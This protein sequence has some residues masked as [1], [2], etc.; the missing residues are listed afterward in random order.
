M[1]IASILAGSPHL[2]AIAESARSVL[3]N[4]DLGPLLVYLI[5]TTSSDALPYL[6]DQF[7]VLGYGGFIIAETEE[8]QRALLKKAL[9]LQRYKGTVWAIKESLQA[10]G[11]GSPDILEGIGG[12]VP[13]YDGTQQFDGSITFAD[14]S[15]YDWATFSVVLDL[16]E[17]RGVTALST[18]TAIKIIEEY[19]NARSRLIGVT[20]K[21]TLLDSIA[22]NDE[23]LGYS[24]NDPF[25][26]NSRGAIFSG[27]A[28]FSGAERYLGTISDASD[29]RVVNQAGNTVLTDNF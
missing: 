29:I 23:G 24:Q 15:A 7:G 1:N 18:E 26:E 16:G 14:A 8:Q 28:N 9:E 3:K 20:F 25:N 13:T 2:T 10:L 11:Y 17:S 4:T 19:K 12:Y 5:E 6:A 27:S 22:I 21:A